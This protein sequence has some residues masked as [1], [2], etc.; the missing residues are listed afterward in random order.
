MGVRVAPAVTLDASIWVAALRINEPAHD[1]ADQL[2]LSL[3]KQGAQFVQP[4]L[5]AIEVGGAMRRRTGDVSRAQRAVD[6]IASL[7]ARLVVID[8]IVAADATSIAVQAGIAGADAC[9]VATSR[10]YRTTLLTLD[11][12]LISRAAALADVCHP[13]TWLERST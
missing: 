7:S 2:L 12:T 1:V 10:Q 13:R 4:T 6:R 11:E 8:E 5:F 3:L 9:Y